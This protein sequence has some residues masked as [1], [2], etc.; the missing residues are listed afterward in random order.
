MYELWYWPSI[1]GRGE[2]P[3]LAME[4]G[5]IPYRDMAREAGEDGYAALSR[6]LALPRQ[7][8]PFGATLSDR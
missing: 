5:G 7:D 3:R 8:P 4:A 2:F 6:N 1:P